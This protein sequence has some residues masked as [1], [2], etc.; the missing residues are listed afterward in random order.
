V[1]LQPARKRGAD[2]KQETARQTWVRL[3]PER[4]L[5]F[6]LTLPLLD[7][8]LHDLRMGPIGDLGQQEPIARIEAAPCLT[9]V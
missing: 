8:E 4:S 2:T 9:F 5:F 6:G 1:A 3:A 7:A